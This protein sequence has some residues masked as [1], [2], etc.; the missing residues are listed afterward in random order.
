MSA[1]YVVCCANYR[2]WQPAIPGVRFEVVVVLHCL[3]PYLRAPL[4]M[5]ASEGFASV[6]PQQRRLFCLGVPT[7][8]APISQFDHVVS[9]I[10]L[11]PAAFVRQEM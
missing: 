11:D 1:P 7:L 6:K 2:A 4:H 8:S 5:C 10:S 3:V 9:V